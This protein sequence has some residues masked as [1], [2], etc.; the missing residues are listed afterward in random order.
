MSPAE[1]AR[2]RT[3]A[4]R[5]WIAVAV[6]ASIA[7][8]IVAYKELRPRRPAPPGVG[9]RVGAPASGS[10]TGAASVLLFADPAEAE[11]PCG[12]GRI[13]RLVRAAATRGVAVREV[14]PGSEPALERAYRVTVVPSVLVLDSGGRV[15]ARHEGENS[16]T[17]GA[18]RADLD[19]LVEAAR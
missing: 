14:A 10:P 1:G 7:G 8:G 12:C 9:G 2:G 16:G 13:I 5:G 4:V 18:I 15:A 6:A 17:I 3:A 19:R 11:S